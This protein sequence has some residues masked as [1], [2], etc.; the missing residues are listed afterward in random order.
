MVSRDYMGR[1]RQRAAGFS[2]VEMLVVLAVVGLALGATA[3]SFRSLHRQSARATAGQM[4]SGIRYLYDRAITT[5][6]YYRLVIDLGSQTYWA[7]TS[8]TRF[9]L[10]RGKEDSKKGR[11]PDLDA[12]LKKLDD[13]E[14]RKQLNITGVA[15]KLQPPPMPKRA[16]FESFKDASLPKVTMRG[17]RVRDIYTR[18]QNEPYTDGK[19][20]L[21]FFPDGHTEKALIHV[22][23][24]E[25]DVYTLVVQPLTGRVTLKPGDIPASRELDLDD[26]GRQ[27]ADH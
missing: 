3:V 10:A 25:G 18:R 4:S 20:Y 19:A 15:A 9:F 24:D 13:E 16:R 17:A 6:S 14:K 1:R 23:D 8:D 27:I 2:L 5:G 22:V 26:E 11:A 7:E 12:A 21:Y